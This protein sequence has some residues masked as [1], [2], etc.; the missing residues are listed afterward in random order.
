MYMGRV[1]VTQ[2]QMTKVVFQISRERSYSFPALI[3]ISTVVTVVPARDNFK[4]SAVERRPALRSW[5]RICCP[6][7]Y[8]ALPTCI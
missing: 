7:L 4:L 3:V 2:V 1:Y 5:D 8:I 6:G